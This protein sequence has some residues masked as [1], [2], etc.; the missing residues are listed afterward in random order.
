MLRVRLKCWALIPV[1]GLFAR[2][3]KKFNPK[4]ITKMKNTFRH[5][6]IGS[7]STATLRTE[8]LLESFQSA[9]EGLIF[10]NGDYFSL[11]ENFA[12]RDRL[13]GILGAAQVV[14][15]MK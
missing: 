5:A 11:P 12:Q 3:G 10:V 8:D 7:V 1:S 2:F 15:L 4:P 6:D 14:R 9:L 13:N